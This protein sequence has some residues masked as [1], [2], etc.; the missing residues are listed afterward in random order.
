MEPKR[1]VIT[2]M[3]IVSPVGRT[4]ETY[5]D[6]LVAGKSG[7]SRYEAFDSTDYDTK[8]AGEIKDL[9]VTDYIDR[10]EARRMD[11][12]THFA[13]IAAQQAVRDSEIR[14]DSVDRE[15]FGVIVSSGIGGMR[16]YEKE[17]Q[18]LLEKGPGRVSPLLIPMLIADIAPGYISIHHGLK[19]VN[20]ATI[21]ACASSA[22]AI[23]AAFNHIRYGEA[24]GMLA[25]GSE[26]PITRMGVSGFNAMRAISTRNDEPERASRPF[27]LDRDGFVMGEGG[28][29]LLLEE[30]SHARA[31]GAKIYAELA[32]IGFSADAY[33]ITAPDADGDGAYRCMRT[34]LACAGMQPKD[35]DYINAHGTST[36]LNDK[37]ETVAIK[38]VFGDYAYQLAISSTKSMV[39][40]ILGGSGAVEA[41]ACVMTLNKQI[42][43]PT[44]NYETPDPDCDL[45]YVPNKAV[46][47]RVQAVMSNSFGFGGH[48]V[49]LLFKEFSS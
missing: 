41:I 38:R 20:Y 34:A 26:A 6:N 43:H 15:K 4:V 25:G 47:R 44:I 8:I 1:V 23:G 39:G 11:R 16:I 19:G 30:L 42:V 13:V 40:H 27:D 29:V 37:S 36:P 45:N 5:F 33:H 31:R 22:H 2:G 28:A 48:N 12:F 10:K 7:I 35:I 49:S 18:T 3:G 14:F 17:C 24:I 21:S 32:G 9:E 46:K